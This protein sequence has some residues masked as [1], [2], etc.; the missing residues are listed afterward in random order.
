EQLRAKPKEPVRLVGEAL[1]QARSLLFDRGGLLDL[2]TEALRDYLPATTLAALDQLART[3]DTAVAAVPPAAPS[4]M[5]VGEGSVVDLPIHLRGNHLTLAE[6]KVPRGV[7]GAL[8]G[9]APAPTMPSDRSG[10]RELARWMFDPSLPLAARV[11]AN[12]IWQRAFGEG[13]SRS[14]SNF[15]NRGDVPVHLDLLD[16]LARDLAD[17]GWS[18]KRLWRTIL[19]SRAWQ[20]SAAHREDAHN[21]DPE[22]RYL[23]RA[24]RRRLDAES[25]RDAMLAATGELDRA[26]GGSLLPTR[27]RDYVTNDQSNDRASYDSLRRS[28]YLPI[29]RNAMFDMFTAF[30]Y[31]D[32]SIHMECRP[33]S[34]V[35]TQ[36]LLLLNGDFVLAR[37]RTLAAS[38]EDAPEATDELRITALWRKALSRDP[39]TDEVARAVAW[40]QTARNSGRP[41]EAFPG[42][43]QV[44][45]ASSEFLYVD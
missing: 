20:Q 39:S 31:V 37:S 16:W 5:A 43:A 1:E 4:A 40:L 3:R 19:L 9:L 18:Q 26:L 23:W 15:G 17:H 11:Q 10:R 33:T 44:L 38:V 34:A 29:I 41:A 22:N 8:V 6:N 30:D 45:F 12:R 42:L 25:V 24:E 35:A 13:L 27:D 2:P 14:P 32:P 7:I 28:L 21:A 36:A